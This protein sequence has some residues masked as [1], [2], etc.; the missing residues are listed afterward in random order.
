MVQG[1]H[2]KVKQIGGIRNLSM[3]ER[4]PI[5]VSLLKKMTEQNP[6][7]TKP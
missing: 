4:V 3:P 1:K 6:V 5:I 2:R 7:G